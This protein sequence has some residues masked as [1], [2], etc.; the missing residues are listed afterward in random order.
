MNYRRSELILYSSGEKKERK[1]IISEIT[2]LIYRKLENEQTEFNL[3][4]QNQDK[5]VFASNYKTQVYF[6]CA[7]LMV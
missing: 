6:L 4:V 7:T 1:M 5:S 3:L 2:F